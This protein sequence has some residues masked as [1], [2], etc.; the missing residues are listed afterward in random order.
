MK[1]ISSKCNIFLSG[2]EKF[3]KNIFFE[4]SFPIHEH[5]H[6]LPKNACPDYKIFHLPKIVIQQNLPKKYCSLF[7][8]FY[9]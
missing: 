5:N 2:I 6:F 8:Y 7:N 9:I 1:I 4:Q 3:S